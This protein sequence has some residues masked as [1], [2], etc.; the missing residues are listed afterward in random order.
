[1][2]LGNFI[3]LWKVEKQNKKQNR[4]YLKMLTYE[5]IPPI[6]QYLRKAINLSEFYRIL[7]CISAGQ[8]CWQTGWRAPQGSPRR[9]AT[10][11]G[12]SPHPALQSTNPQLLAKQSEW[13]RTNYSIIIINIP[14]IINMIDD[15]DRKDV[16]ISNKSVLTSILSISS[17]NWSWLHYQAEWRQEPSLLSR[18]CSGAADTHIFLR[19]PVIRPQTQ[20][21]RAE[22][23]DYILTPNIQDWQ[24]GFCLHYE[25]WT[26]EILDAKTR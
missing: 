2:I 20:W 6:K 21:R 24:Y 9:I 5:N 10:A 23:T 22:L 15:N 8:L 3:C 7:S 4:K 26:K 1:M 18:L 16:L 25:E 17:S 13:K 11:P 12:P 19:V 14:I